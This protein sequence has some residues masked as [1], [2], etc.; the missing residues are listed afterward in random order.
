MTTPFTISA[1]I[2]AR[3]GREADAARVLHDLLAPTHSEPGCIQYDMHR[4]LEDP[5]V[6]LFFENWKSKADWEA[7]METP[8]LR[9]FVARGDELLEGLEVLQLEKVD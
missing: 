4:S 5:R 6:F 2:T 7:H 3:P 9:D 1:K 8:Y